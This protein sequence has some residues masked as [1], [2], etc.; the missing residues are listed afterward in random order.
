MEAIVIQT[1]RETSPSEGHLVDIDPDA[2][3]F[4]WPSPEGV[5][6][7]SKELRFAV[8]DVLMP[9]G[10]ER[11][12]LED[13]HGLIGYPTHS[14]MV[15]LS[16][17]IS[18]PYDFVTRLPLRLQADVLNARLQQENELPFTISRQPM[19]TP[20]PG[21]TLV[22][23]PE[24]YRIVTNISPGWRGILPHG[25]VAQSALN[26]ARDVYGNDIEI[27]T[28]TMTDT[29]MDLRLVCPYSQEITTGGRAVGDVV[30]LGIHVYHRYG[31]E[32]GCS[33][34]L[35]RLVCLNGM[36]AISSQ[37]EWKQ[38]LGGDPARQLE[39]L[40]VGVANAIGAYDGVIDRLRQ[41][42]AAPLVGDM[43]RIV[44]ERSRAMRIP[45]THEEAIL[46]A[47]RQEP[48]PSEYGVLNAFTRFATHSDELN[49]R[50]RNRFQ[51]M[52]GTWASEFDV[53]N[54]RL[55]R[56]IAENVG[57]TIYSDEE[58]REMFA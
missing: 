30:A 38:A 34:Y 53:V 40:Y 15:D 51:S 39:W 13:V 6:L 35:R 28:A 54:A 58:A 52:A 33:L 21:G 18:F 43:E 7:K 16:T 17:R 56:S 29:R 9:S 11:L 37:F 57:A 36:T 8:D 24:G 45:R 32:L 42:A 49:D 25:D 48:N 26:I 23:R 2:P 50:Q 4:S 3:W 41:M 27:Q 14:G 46:T 31:M 12:V 22:A 1:E 10:G 19:M 44:L 55:P 5:S 20:G 47:W